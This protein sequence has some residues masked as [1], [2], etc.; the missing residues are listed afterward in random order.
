[1]QSGTLGQI[2]RTLGVEAVPVD[3]SRPGQ[4]IEI[5]VGCGGVEDAEAPAADGGKGLAGSE[6]YGTFE[7]RLG[8]ER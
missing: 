8:H 4:F 1:M 2:A 3:G 5:L 6:S 7:K